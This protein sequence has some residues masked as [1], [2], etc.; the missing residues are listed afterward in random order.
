MKI[1]T[2]GWTDEKGIIRS[3]VEYMVHVL[4][5]LHVGDTTG[6]YFHLTIPGCALSISTDGININDTGRTGTGK[7]HLAESLCHTLPK[8]KFIWGSLTDNVIWYL[9]EKRPPG[10]IMVLDDAQTLTPSQISAIK[11]ITTK[12]QEGARRYITDLRT[13]EKVIEILLPPRLAFIFTSVEGGFDEQL[14][15]RTMSVNA[16]GS[17]KQDDLVHEFD[18]ERV[19]SGR[20]K[21]PETHE[22]KVMR[23]MWTILFDEKPMPVALEAIDHINFIFKRDRR[24]FPLFKDSIIAFACINQKMRNRND[25]GDLLPEKADFDFA[26]KFWNETAAAQ[27]LKYNDR[28]LQVLDYL[29]N[30][31]LGTYRQKQ[32]ETEL[33][34][35]QP[36]MHRALRGRKIPGTDDYAGGLVNKLPGI[37]QLSQGTERIGDITEKYTNIHYHGDAKLLE[38]YQAIAQWID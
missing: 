8:K 11:Q 5:T 30:K 3:P 28:E 37:V 7:S 38:T 15:D 36:D 32:V 29:V 33:K 26:M 17:E 16:D 34:M 25:N 9:A 2:E 27:H 6:K 1:L 18:I 31:G 10:L 22:V 4:D 35:S 12:Y 13:K 20:P 23:E 24:L 19:R 21:F 14:L